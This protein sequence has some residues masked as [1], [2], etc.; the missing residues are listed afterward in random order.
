[1]Q[2]AS[3]TAPVRRPFPRHWLLLG[4][5]VA[6]CAPA[7]ILR[8]LLVTGAIAELPSV[9]TVLIFGSSIVAAAFLI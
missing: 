8:L 7:P 4:V 5:S 3:M 6:A 2:Q 9:P 1:M